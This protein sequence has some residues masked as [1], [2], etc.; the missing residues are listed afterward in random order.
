MTLVNV[1]FTEKNQ[2]NVLLRYENLEKVLS[3]LDLYEQFISKHDCDINHEGSA[4]AME[5][6]G[7]IECFMESGKN[8]LLHYTSYIGDGNTKSCSEVVKRDPYPGTVVQKLECVGHIQRRVGG[9]L[10]N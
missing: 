1:L 2:S 10:Q 6:S 3:L 9:R 5:K 8:R 7:L 4:G